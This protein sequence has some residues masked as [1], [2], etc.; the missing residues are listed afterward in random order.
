[1]Y[2]YGH[3]MPDTEHR[4]KGIGTQTHVCMLSHIL[5]TLSF[6]LHGIVAR[7]QS[8]DLYLLALYLRRLSGTLTL[9]Q[10]TRG[11]NTC[12]GRDALQRLG[13]HR[14]RV[15]HYL[16]ILNGRSVVQC[17]EVHCLAAAVR[18][19]PSLYRDLLS[20]VGAAKRIDDSC[21]ATHIDY[22]YKQRSQGA[23]LSDHHAAPSRAI[24]FTS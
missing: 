21:S 12:A 15:Y 8:V 16:N 10:H 18:P 3:V 14:C 11:T 19:Y 22:I 13:I 2:G 5:K 24:V 7:A 23:K 17:D 1:M 4:A 20:I 6:L 9:H